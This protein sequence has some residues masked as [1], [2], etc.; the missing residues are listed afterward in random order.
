M[1]A[2]APLQPAAGLVVHL[3]NSLSAIEDGRLAL[4][5]YLAPFRLDDRI[6]NRLEIVLEELV[7]NV[8]RHN[9]AATAVTV[10]AA[11]RD[12][13]IKLT[14][15]DNGAA[16][17]PFE[18]TTPS[19]FTTLEDAKLGGLGVPLVRRLTERLHYERI[20]GCNRTSAV[21]AAR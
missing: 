2:E 6:I 5:S 9:A 19:R 1:T 8:V 20:S 21:I 17:D 16:F 12:G 14:I 15:E 7:S 11:Y 3:A 18:L 10:E 4:L 13:T